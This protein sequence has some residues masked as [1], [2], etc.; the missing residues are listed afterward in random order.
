VN[1]SSKHTNSS[2]VGR[3]S[4]SIQSPVWSS[5]SSVWSGLLQ[6]FLVKT[7]H[8]PYRK[9]LFFCL[10]QKECLPLGCLVTSYNDVFTIVACI[11][12]C[13]NVY[14][15][16]RC[17]ATM[18]FLYCYRNGPYVTILSAHL[19]PCLSSDT[20]RLCFP[21][22]TLCGLYFNAFCVL[23]P[24]HPP[25]Y[26]NSNNICCGVRIM[27]FLIIRFS[28]VSCCFMLLMSRYS[29]QH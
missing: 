14:G 13:E 23:C 1:K 7:P 16:V 2:D 29:L 15:V 6:A 11:P 9:H 8:G 10:I 20:F 19:C 22:R 28:P 25:L 4:S 26:D 17:L 27:G 21:S 24:S 18:T 3:L 5:L 12:C